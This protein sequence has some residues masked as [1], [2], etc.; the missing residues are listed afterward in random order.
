MK[1]VALLLSVLTAFGSAPAFAGDGASAPIIY[2]SCFRG[3]WEEVIWDRANPVFV[4]SLIKVGYDYPSAYA[5]G[6]RICRDKSLVN[7]AEGM[8]REMIRIFNESPKYHNPR[9]RAR[10]Y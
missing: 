7:D 2:V 9:L 8:K 6:E 10:S 4:D 5:I 1:K 3:P